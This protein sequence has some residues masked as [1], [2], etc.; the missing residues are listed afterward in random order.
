MVAA[1]VAPWVVTGD[2]AG[3]VM[4]GKEMPMAADDPQGLLPTPRASRLQR[5]S[6]KDGR[7]VVGVL[8]VLLAVVLGAKAV[9][10]AGHTVPLYVAAHALVPGQQVRTRDLRSTQVRLDGAD[11]R[12]LSAA[13]APRPGM[14]VLRSVAAG[15][16]VP[17]S[18]LGSAQ[19]I[20][21]RTVSVPV[22]AAGAAM[23]SPGSVVEVWVDARSGSSLSAQYQHP[24]RVLSNATV[25]R[26]PEQS[27]ALGIATTSSSVQ[28]AVPHSQVQ[29]II[30]A[31]DAGAKVTL[32]PT[33]GVS[34]GGGS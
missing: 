28:I 4:D 29:Q 17:R 14:Y 12:Y 7:L 6:W 11:E 19:Q 3:D 16:L 9:S 34:T 33:A 32:V 23:L 8:L 22:D 15:E 18:A 13:S 10:A 25:A 31:V 1:T 26:V 20:D 5:P 30:A 24:R 27:G 2:L 21:T